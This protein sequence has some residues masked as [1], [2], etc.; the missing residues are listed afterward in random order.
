MSAPVVSGIDQGDIGFN[1]CGAFSGFS[2]YDNPLDYCTGNMGINPP[3][4]YNFVNEQCDDNGGGDSGDECNLLDTD[5]YNACGPLLGGNCLGAGLTSG[6]IDCG[7]FLD[8]ADD[9]GCNAGCGL[10]PACPLDLIPHRNFNGVGINNA[11]G[12]CPDPDFPALNGAIGGCG[13][14]V[15]RNGVGIGNIDGT[16]IGNTGAFPTD[17]TIVNRGNLCNLTKCQRK[18]LEKQCRKRAK[19][20]ACLN[21]C[22]DNNC[23]PNGTRRCRQ[24]C[25]TK[26]QQ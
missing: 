7:A 15:G 22:R 16:I 4:C 6:F 2:E 25:V 10:A 5:P 9:I 19:L 1:D 11:D 21:N 17:G 23:N 20:R 26:S 8:D 24:K 3:D 12:F 18:N 13:V 14:G